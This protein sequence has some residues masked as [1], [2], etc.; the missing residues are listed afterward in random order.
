MKQLACGSWF[1]LSFEHF[2]VIST[3]DKSTDH[4]KLLSI[5][6]FYSNAT[7][8]VLTSL[9]ISISISQLN[10]SFLQGGN[11]GAGLV[12][13]KLFD[14]QK[15]RHDFVV[16]TVSVILVK[17]R[18]A[19][20]VLVLDQRE[21]TCLRNDVTSAVFLMLE[22]HTCTRGKPILPIKPA[23]TPCKVGQG[24]RRKRSNKCKTTPTNQ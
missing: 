10:R 8:K 15:Y 12:E 11:C 22:S 17:T 7:L 16:Y 18:V 1:L 21:L 5:S 4:G 23:T 14:G 6:E 20:L 2:V 24:L 13:R 3:V 9:E 19:P